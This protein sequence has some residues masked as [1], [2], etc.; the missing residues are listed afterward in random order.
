MINRK[1]F[2]DLHPA[3][4]DNL[5]NLGSVYRDLNNLP[6]AEDYYRQVVALDTKIFGDNNPT[7]AGDIQMLGGVLKRQ[8]KLE[9]AE[10]VYRETLQIKLKHFPAD[11]WQV[12]TTKNLLG[13]CLTDQKAYA[14]AEPL[15]LE[16]TGVIEKQFGAGHERT[17]AATSAGCDVVQNAG[18]SP[19]RP[20][21]GER[22]CRKEARSSPQRSRCWVVPQS[23]ADER[24]IVAGRS[25]CYGDRDRQ[26]TVNK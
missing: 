6:K 15:L 13:D 22:S 23:G 1:A 2:G 9:E 5:T 24:W 16:S 4:T 8:K 12:A 25:R 26:P 20:L 17:K 11:H 19:P 18:A 10:S 7:V 21:N 14:A 3:V